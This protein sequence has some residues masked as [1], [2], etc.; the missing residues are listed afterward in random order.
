MLIFRCYEQLS[1]HIESVSVVPHVQ[2]ASDDLFPFSAVLMIEI[3]QLFETILLHDIE[4]KDFHI[5]LWWWHF[6][7]QEF[8]SYNKYQ[9]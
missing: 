6:I 8:A 3:G 7:S 4:L 2:T 1:F 5:K 9:R